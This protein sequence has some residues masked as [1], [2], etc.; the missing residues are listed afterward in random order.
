MIRENRAAASPAPSVVRSVL[1]DA[2][3]DPND[4]DDYY[5]GADQSVSEHL[6][7]PL[8]VNTRRSSSRALCRFEQLCEFTPTILENGISDWGRPR[9]CSIEQLFGW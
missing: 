9:V 3:Y 5:Q 6:S 1:E 2:L 4:Q 8:L 7:L